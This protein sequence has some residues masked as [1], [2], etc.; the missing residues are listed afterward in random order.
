MQRHI[1]WGIVGLM[2]MLGCSRAWGTV[3]NLQTNL[4]GFQEVPP[5]SSPGFGDADVT[6]NDATDLVTITSGSFSDL[7][8]GSTTI[9]LSDAAAGS[10]GPTIFTLT[11]NNPGATS[12]TFDGSGTITATQATDMLAGN[13]YINV[14]SNVYPSGEI[15]GQLDVVPEPASFGLLAGGALLMLR[16][17]RRA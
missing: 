7:L 5:N 8:G 9:R 1:V 13:T 11:N 4:D 2:A 15:R 16:R 3:W 6:L 10:N 12:G 14:Q 17:K